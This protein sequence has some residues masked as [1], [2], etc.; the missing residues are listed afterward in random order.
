[1]LGSDDL[2]REWGYTALSRHRDEARY[3]AVSPGSVERALPGLEPEPDPLVEDLREVLADS[4]RKEMA[5]ELADRDPAFNERRKR[6]LMGGYRVVTRAAERAEEELGLAEEAGRAEEQR[7]APSKRR[8]L[9]RREEPAAERESQAEPVE[10]ARRA[11]QAAHERRASWIELHGD[12]LL[13]LVDSPT[14]NR[15]LD[16]V[17]SVLNDPPEELIDQL[18]PRPA[19]VLDRDRWSQAA[20]DAFDAPAPDLRA[21][22]DVGL[23]L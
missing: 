15:S 4:R 20:A 6:E 7:R 16:E 8:W 10:E 14:V 12:E 18:G 9:G 19:S 21:L 5:L 2:Y 11:A 3:Y 23:D 1:M 22:D 13:D 17:R